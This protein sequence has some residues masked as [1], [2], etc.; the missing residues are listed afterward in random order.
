MFR[1]ATMTAMLD[2]SLVAEIIGWP[3][4]RITGSQVF[5][6]EG[7]GKHRLFSHAEMR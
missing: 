5:F 3:W 7:Q 2:G 6:C 4:L 1:I